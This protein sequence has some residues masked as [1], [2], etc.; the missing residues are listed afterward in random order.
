MGL[1]DVKA[2]PLSSITCFTLTCC[3]KDVLS[4]GGGEVRGS[5]PCLTSSYRAEKDIYVITLCIPVYVLILKYGVFNTHVPN[6]FSYEKKTSFPWNWIHSKLYSIKA[7]PYLSKKENYCDYWK[8][9]LHSCT[10][11]SDFS[12][13]LEM[14]V[15]WHLFPVRCRK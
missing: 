3:C 9:V 4:H 14:P 12:D 5:G 10:V 8:H 1:I 6:C 2:H 13:F 7:L 15:W 11:K